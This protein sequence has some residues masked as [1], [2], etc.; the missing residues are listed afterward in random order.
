MTRLAAHSSAPQGR[1][2]LN[3][4]P[5]LFA[6]AAVLVA[7]W[8]AAAEKTPAP[9]PG[10]KDDAVPYHLE[11]DV[12]EA[13][14]SGGERVLHG[15]GHVVIVHGDM[16]ITCDEAYSYEEKKMATLAGNVV[17]NDPVQKYTLT[18]GY[19]EYRRGEKLAVATKSPKLVLHK[20]RPVTITAD[21]MQMWTETENG[22]ASGNVHVVSKD[23][24]G[25]GQTLKYF[26]KEDRIEL[27][28]NPV[29]TQGDSRL[30]ADVITMF[31]KDEK[32]E[33]ALADG[34]ARLVYFSRAEKKSGGTAPKSAGGAGSGAPVDAAGET[35]S[36][37]GAGVT[38]P[39]GVGS[40]A[41]EGT[42]AGDK[43]G[44]A[45]GGVAETKE[46]N[47][48]GRV[49]AAGAQMDAKFAD[50]KL[51]LVDI[52]GNAE[53]H[54]WPFDDAGRETGEQV[55]AAGDTIRIMMAEGDVKK[56]VVNGNAEGV[57]RPAKAEGRSG[58]TQTAG[59]R[60]SVF[61]LDRSVRR[62]TVYG[63]ARGSYYTEETPAGKEAETTGG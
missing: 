21:I 52:V 7:A 37:D 57:Y 5:W 47:P 28:G 56:I 36:A 24:D 27:R 46:E 53:G 62:I 11:S 9:A 45:G 15:M 61:V 49:E 16:T 32:L 14:T 29:V 39:P 51:N 18:S 30:A 26:G 23:M 13:F 1:N 25:Y 55:D 31:L 40:P 22:E 42:A 10:A 44:A 8:A 2:A 34:G 60:I 41:P 59:D 35:P 63:H 50:G 33:R 54:Y 19:G 6:G 3:T 48:T 38:E 12:T 20:G 4:R 58:V 17:V 43:A